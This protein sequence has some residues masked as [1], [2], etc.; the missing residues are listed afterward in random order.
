M[1]NWRSM[2]D[3]VIE[4]TIVPSFGRSGY[5]IRKRIH[6]WEP[7]DGYNLDGQVIVIT[8]ATSGIGLE[9]ARVFAERRA[10]VVIVGRDAR[11]NGET[12]TA[13]G[14][15]TGNRAVSFAS[16]DMGDL[17]QVGNLAR[18]LLDRY[19]QLDIL[20]H[21]AG[22]LSQQRQTSPDGIEVTVASQVVGPF[23]LTALLLDRL[24]LSGSSRVL[25]MASGGLYTCEL[26]GDE[27]EMPTN[28]YRGAEQYG[29]AKR[30]QVTLTELWAQRYGHLGIRFHTTHPG[31]VRTPGL[32]KS[33]PRFNSMLGP[34]LRSC[35]QGAD[36][37]VWLACDD[38]ALNTNGLFWHDRQP[39]PIHRIART[40]LSDTDEQRSRL[41]SWVL[42]QC[43]TLPGHLSTID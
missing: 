25:T 15:A 35:P 23:L 33:L 32:A 28:A 36:T 41:W 42:S 1:T 26:F 39:R 6:R 40:Q 7:L 21:N 27:I 19:E 5:S 37:L 17:N 9:A 18:E 22:A 20:V 10:T 43:P 31:W 3:G 29:R 14:A 11:R 38:E 34:V 4:S 13:L 30:A 24:S 8:G 2:V 12:A 16:A